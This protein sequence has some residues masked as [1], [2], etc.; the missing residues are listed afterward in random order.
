[1]SVLL[2]GCTTWTFWNAWR[3]RL[4]ENYARMLQFVLNKPWK[5]HST[6]QQL[7]GHL[8]SI[9]QMTHGHASV[10]QPYIHE[11]SEW[12]LDSAKRTC[13]DD[14]KE[15]RESRL[16]HLD[17][18]VHSLPL[19]MTGLFTYRLVLLPGISAFRWGF[20][21]NSCV[22]FRKVTHTRSWGF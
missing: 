12:T 21:C 5:Q 9:L 22:F 3:K 16:S 4:D 20:K 18:N 15:S 13:Q 14:E 7:Y 19:K 8:L 17:D 1:M 2:Y 10:G 11:F 6:K